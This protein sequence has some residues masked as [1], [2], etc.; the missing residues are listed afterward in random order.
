MCKKGI[1][2]KVDG[3]E[4]RIHAIRVQK[5]EQVLVC[6]FVARGH[7]DGKTVNVTEVE[8]ANKKAAKSLKEILNKLNTKILNTGVKPSPC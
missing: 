8:P 4:G 5:K 1:A 6:T 3:Q 7:T 2:G